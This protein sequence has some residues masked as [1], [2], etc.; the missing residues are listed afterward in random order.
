[1]KIYALGDTHLSLGP[2]VDKPMEVFGSEWEDH[3]ERLRKNWMEKITPDDTV[4]ICG[5]ISWG[6][7]LDEAMPD[8]EFLH[9]LPGEKV[10]TKGNHDLW[11]TSVSKLNGLH[12][13]MIFLQN[14][15]FEVSDG[16]CVCGTRGWTCPGSDGFE[17][18][19]EK[20]Y[21]RE[22]GRLRLSLEDA[23]KKNASE[24]ICMLHYP[25]TNEHFQPSGFTDLMTEH[26]VKLCIYGHL[27]GHDAWRRGIRGIL[28]GVDYRLV[29]LDHIK[30]DP[31]LIEEI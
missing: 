18:H 21:E 29:S 13:D 4:L 15:A 25:P 22:V 7:R 17:E 12:D 28:N 30:C 1:M 2:G 8:L 16:I 14:K 6:L 24:K 11:W 5:D 3:A 31:V 20:I 26:G 9:G 23:E 10:L 19:D 27:H